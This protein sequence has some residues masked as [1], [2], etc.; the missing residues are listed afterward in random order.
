S[1][2]P[3]PAGTTLAQ[4][5]Q[6]P[7]PAKLEQPEKTPATLTALI[8]PPPATDASTEDVIN[9]GE[10][11]AVSPATKENT[12]IE[13]HKELKDSAQTSSVASNTPTLDGLLKKTRRWM[14]D[15]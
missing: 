5:R 10:A 8:D 13:T 2:E 4:E 12:I 1:V 6:S 11:A 9:A 3:S 7:Q 15:F 14:H